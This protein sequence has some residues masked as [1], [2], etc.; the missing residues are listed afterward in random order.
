MTRVIENAPW[1]HR[2]QAIRHNQA[3][4]RFGRREAPAESSFTGRS[5]QT[6]QQG[7]G[8][9]GSVAS[10][11]GA[12]GRATGLMLLLAEED[13]HAT[14]RAIACDKESDGAG[15]R[16][17]ENAPQVEIQSEHLAFPDDAAVLQYGRVQ[18]MEI[19]REHLVAFQYLDQRAPACHCPSDRLVGGTRGFAKYNRPSKRW[20]SRRRH[21]RKTA[22][23]TDCAGFTM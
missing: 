9:T 3:Y 18:R 6:V 21:L 19:E 12:G 5:R 15:V 22:L 14:L 16:C 10:G 13:L 7:I 4:I 23:R 1:D 20:R 17:D 2:R 8:Q 11:S